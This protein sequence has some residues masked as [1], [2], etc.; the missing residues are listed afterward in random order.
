MLHLE[1]AVV[2]QSYEI[3]GMPV[4][5]CISPGG[6]PEAWTEVPVLCQGG[7]RTDRQSVRPPSVGRIDDFF[8]IDE[9]EGAQAILLRMGRHPSEVYCIGFLRH[10]D[11]EVKPLS[12]SPVI[13]ATSDHDGT[14]YDQDWFEKHSNTAL[15]V[16]SKGAHVV[17]LRN[18]EQPFMQ[19][20]LPSNGVVRISRD[21]EANERLVL[22]GALIDYLGRLET[23]ISDLTTAISAATSTAPGA[24]IG[25]IPPFSAIPTAGDSL[26]SATIRV[27]EDSE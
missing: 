9:T 7:G 20:Q 21:D 8:L 15:I 14:A 5:D 3:G 27:S 17:D 4:I 22:G 2:T 23:Y 13:D 10:A 19:V 12:D 25:F 26:K 16:T 1:I 18:A 6:L 11:H 24:P